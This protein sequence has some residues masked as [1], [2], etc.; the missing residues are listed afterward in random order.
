MA[1]DYVFSPTDPAT[2]SLLGKWIGFKFVVYNFVQ[3]GKTVVKTQNWLNVNNDK[4]TWVKVESK[5]RCWWI[6]YPATRCSGYADQIITWGGPI[7][8]FRWDSATNT[9]FKNLSVREIQPPLS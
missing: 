8:T 7:A 4:I 1:C 9:D 3:N 5:H 2:S 6:G